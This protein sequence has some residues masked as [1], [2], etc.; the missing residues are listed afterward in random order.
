MTKL[1]RRL[2][3]YSKKAPVRED[4]DQLGIVWPIPYVAGE[5]DDAASAVRVAPVI[6]CAERKRALSEGGG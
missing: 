1:I 2:L 5:F 4:A 3:A 6:S